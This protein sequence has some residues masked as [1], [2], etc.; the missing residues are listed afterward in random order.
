MIETHVD[1]ARTAVERERSVLEAERAA[2]EQFRRQVSSVSATEMRQAT[3]G[4]AQ[5]AVAVRAGRTDA[6]A[7]ACEQVRE[8]F[9]ETIRPHSV[10]DVDGEESLLETIRAEFGDGI[11]LALAPTT[12]AGFTAETKRAVLTAAREREREIEATVDSLD[13][14]AASL[15]EV[16]E[17]VTEITEW[18]TD[19]DETPLS[20]LGFEELRERH[21]RLAE[22]RERCSELLAERQALLLSTTGRNR[23]ADVSHRA[24]VRY[25]YEP[26][27]VVFPVLSTVTR[28]YDLI[29]ECQRAVR[30][31]LTR[32]G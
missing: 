21:D 8:A 17:T 14:E 26:L 30:A 22:Y 6:G 24:L 18:V 4:A 20:E 23:S 27:P 25:L 10:A 7:G 29:E 1:R 2:Y 31:Y 12:G 5:G 11:A 13:S 28:L 3:G 19:A 16:G 15:R 32:C 9:D